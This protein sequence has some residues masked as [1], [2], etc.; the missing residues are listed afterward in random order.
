MVSEEL[1]G[2][3]GI[4]GDGNIYGKWGI[5]CGGD[6]WGMVG[7]EDMV[8]SEDMVGGVIIPRAIELC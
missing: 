2:N 8:A 6:I 4:M 7:S 1:I 3:G 5:M